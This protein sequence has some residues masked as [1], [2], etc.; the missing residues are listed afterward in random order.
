MNYE[1]FKGIVEDKFMDYLSPQLQGLTLRTQPV[2]KINHRLDSICLYAQNQNSFVSPI[3]YINDMY[4]QYRQGMSL[5]SVL[6]N[7]A[8]H[9]EQ[10]LATAPRGMTLNEK[11]K[12]KIVFQLINTVQNEELL[13]KVP[14][15]EFQDLSIIYRCVFGNDKDG[16]AS[17][18]IQ[19][20]MADQMG[21]SEEQLYR[22]AAENTKKLMPPTIRTMQEVMVE[23][24][25][26]DGVPREDAENMM[27]FMPHEM[28]MYVIG[29]EACV[30]GAASMLYESGLHEL[31][32]RVG[33]DLYI[34]P[35]SVHEVLAIS[36][37][38]KDPYYLAS[39]VEEINMSQVELADRLSNQVYFY[40]K[41][42]REISM[43]TN[44]PNK[45]LDGIVAE[46]KVTRDGMIR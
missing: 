37:K 14:H 4:E 38:D 9:V 21:L 22:L 41:N 32:E 42:L 26:K 17:A 30:N 24:M 46:T 12:D 8:A 6:K 31:A 23:M 36:A 33:S 15:R 1:M 3:I 35:S 34:L 27:D 40:D 25:I 16:V 39:M 11:M 45:R 28:D 43:A 13:A 2:E 44:T 19:N 29:N 20:K 5:E 10:S 18:L 7:A